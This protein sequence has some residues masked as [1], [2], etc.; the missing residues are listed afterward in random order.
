MN[1]KIAGYN[2]LFLLVSGALISTM[3][4][5]N[6]QPPPGYKG[7]HSAVQPSINQSRGERKFAEKPNAI[8]KVAL[9]DLDDVQSNDISQSGSAG[10]GFSWS[11]LLGSRFYFVC[12]F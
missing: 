9:D 4:Y 10:G 5:P 2:M 6:S 7:V 1:S 3:A 8:K 11:N 12:L